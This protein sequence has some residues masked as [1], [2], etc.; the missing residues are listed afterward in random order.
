MGKNAMTHEEVVT[1]VD[2]KNNIIGSEPRSRMRT[3]GLPHRATYILVFNSD[4]ELFVQKRT[5]DKDVY[6][7]FYD[8]AAGGVVKAGETYEKSASRELYEELGV[9]GVALNYLFDFYHEDV[10]NRVWGR[11]YWCVYDGAVR[12]QEEEVESGRFYSIEKILMLI[13]RKRFTP[14]GLYVLQRYLDVN[15]RHVER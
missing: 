2:E 15:E 3:Y 11:S 13:E 5:P 12:L 4:G 6:P 14:D 10:G 8:V 1:I 7:G 9:A